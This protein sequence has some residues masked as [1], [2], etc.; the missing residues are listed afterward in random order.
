MNTTND[1]ISCV[2]QLWLFILVVAYALA[3]AKVA[4]RDSHDKLAKN[5]ELGLGKAMPKVGISD[6]F[7]VDDVA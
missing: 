1:D 7:N 2:Q 6:M 4:P 5:V 3:P